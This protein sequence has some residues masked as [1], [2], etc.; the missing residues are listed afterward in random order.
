VTAVE[1]A[2]RL[3]GDLTP[4]ERRA[5]AIEDADD[6]LVEA[7]GEVGMQARLGRGGAR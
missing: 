6:F 7:Y 1:R 3:A 4:Q 2:E 5:L